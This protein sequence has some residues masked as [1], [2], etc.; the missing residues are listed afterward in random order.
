MF[1][2]CNSLG[3]LRNMLCEVTVAIVANSGGCYLTF[4]RRRG[5]HGGSMM[6]EIENGVTFFAVFY[7]IVLEFDYNYCAMQFVVG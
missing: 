6:I 2:A 5:S 4:N 3:L 7:R 1:N